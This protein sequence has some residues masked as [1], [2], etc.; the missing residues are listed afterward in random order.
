MILLIRS[1]PGLGRQTQTPE[2][3]S[4]LTKPNRSDAAIVSRFGSRIGTGA[5]PQSKDVGD[6]PAGED[7]AHASLDFAEAKAPDLLDGV[8]ATAPRR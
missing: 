6:R 8:G 7:R 5:R 2:N 3:E 4:S 1:G